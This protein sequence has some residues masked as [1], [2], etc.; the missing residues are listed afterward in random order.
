MTL[1]PR[2]PLR[3]LLVEDSNADLRLFQETIKA[4]PLQTALDIFRDGEEVLAFLQQQAPYADAQRPDFIFL[5]MYLPKKTGFQVL[6][7]LEQDATLTTIPVV[8]CIGSVIAK[9]QLESYRLP[10]DCFFLKGYGPE[11]QQRILTHCHARAAAP[12]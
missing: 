4:L 5:D 8:A 10:A 7:E 6:L 2:S 9:Y 1:L 11:Q 12:V 3:L